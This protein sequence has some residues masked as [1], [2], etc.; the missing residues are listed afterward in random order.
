MYSDVVFAYPNQKP[1]FDNLSLTFSP[2]KSYGIVGR[3]G[4]GKTTLVKLLLRFYD[5]Q[6]GSISIHGIRN[7]Q[8]TKS[9][10]RSKIGIVPQETIL[11]NDTLRHNII[12]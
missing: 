10:L 9:H 6:S 4:A 12:Y 5:V 8:L 2:G 3:S 1:I 7:D 11:F